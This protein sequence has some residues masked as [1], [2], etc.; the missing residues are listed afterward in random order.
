M[1]L[2]HRRVLSDWWTQLRRSKVQQSPTL[3]STPDEVK[4]SAAEFKMSQN[5]KDVVPV[6]GTLS[7]GQLQSHHKMEPKTLGAIQLVIAALILCLSASVLNV[8]EVHF[9]GDIALFLFVVFQVRP[10][11]PAAGTGLTGLQTVP[12]KQELHLC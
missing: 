9:T 10:H 7:V 4:A 5:D 8:H 3:V 6:P 11:P 12:Q 1:P 2:R